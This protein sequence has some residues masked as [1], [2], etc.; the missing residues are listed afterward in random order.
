MKTVVISFLMVG[1]VCRNILN[2]IKYFHLF[3]QFHRMSLLQHNNQLPK[4]P[5][6]GKYI[7]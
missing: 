6:I 3:Q 5:E 4:Q 2:K 7:P 1:F